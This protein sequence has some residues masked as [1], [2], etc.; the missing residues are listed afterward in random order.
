MNH[1]KALP[2]SAAISV[3]ALVIAA[4]AFAQELDI[5]EVVVTPNRT[6]TDKAKTGSTVETVS[7]EEIEEQAKPLVVEPSATTCQRSIADTVSSVT[8]S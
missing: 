4:P 3:F 7:K 6:P 2:L 8:G 5:G 1:K